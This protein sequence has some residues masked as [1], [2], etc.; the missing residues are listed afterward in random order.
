MYSFVLFI[1]ENG[2]QFLTLDENFFFHVMC[3]K[4]HLGKYWHSIK[5][6]QKQNF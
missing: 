4:L 5:N 3:V 6:A 2:K 1:I